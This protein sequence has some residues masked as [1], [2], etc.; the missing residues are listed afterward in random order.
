M[1]LNSTHLGVLE[2]AQ[3][4]II[5]FPNGIP[6]FSEM[7]TVA[8]IP[9]VETEQFSN[10]D[11]ASGL[12]FVQST[13]NPDLV[14]LCIDPFLVFP[15]Y[16]VDFDETALAISSASEVLVLAILSVSDGPEPFANRATANLRAPLVINAKARSGCQVVL[17][18]AHWAV[19][20]PL[21][22]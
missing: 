2:I 10:T 18:D 19:K 7:R 6:G 22:S 21:A 8:V 3:D 15:E 13:T 20:H 11:D 1:Q 5:E 17:A 12:F 16:E 14:F 4:R 9:A